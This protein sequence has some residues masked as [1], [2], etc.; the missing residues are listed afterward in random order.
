ME[1]RVSSLSLSETTHPKSSPSSV[2]RLW[3]PAA[4][5]NM[6]NQWSRLNSLR[7]EWFSSSSAARSHA[8]SIVN[9]Y[10]KD[11]ELGVLSD[12]PDIR[13]KACMKLLKQQVLHHDK[14]VS[15]YKDMV[16][17]V[18]NMINTSTSLRCFAKGGTNSSIIQFSNSSE[19]TNDDGDGGGIPVFTFSSISFFE[20]SAS[21]LVQ[22]FKL[23]LY[24]KR[25]LVMEFLSLRSKEDP[26]VKRMCWSDEIYHGES[27]DLSRCDL[28]CRE[29]SESA[30]MKLHTRVSN[31]PLQL[32]SQPD[33]DIL[34][35]YL[36]AWLTDINI[37]KNR[38]EDIFCEVGEEM[39]VN[40]VS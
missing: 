12:I 15:S 19:D 20:K 34:Q 36:T 8:T 39:H 37:D 5:R 13:G 29:A 6:K 4:Q 10:M 3:R 33:S 2:S 14:L 24:L 38:V 21:E 22:M 26:I 40:F 30:P 16:T 35:V 11:M 1:S 27:D 17:I 28:D 18:V 7:Q 32:I 31:N 25:L 9:A 23:E